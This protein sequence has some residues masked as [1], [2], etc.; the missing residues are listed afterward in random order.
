MVNGSEALEDARLSS[1]DPP[2]LDRLEDLRFGVEKSIR[3]HQR[4]RGHY[5]FWNRA[6]KLGVILAGSAAVGSIHP[7]VAGGIAAV[8]GAL[9]LVFDLGN[10]ARDHHDLCRRFS[11]LL[12]EV[13]GKDRP[14]VQDFD[15]WRKQR[16][17]IEADEPPVYWVVEA[18]C[19]NEILYAWGRPRERSLYVSLWRRMM[20]HFCRFESAEFKRIEERLVSARSTLPAT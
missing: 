2:W 15:A 12:A 13:L 20:K 1:D 5:E 7:K 16:L 14:S 4:R 10:K 18:E 19:Y 9:S 8:L 6:T 3:Y 11:N 17:Q